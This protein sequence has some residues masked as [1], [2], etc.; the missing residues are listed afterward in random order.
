MLRRTAAWL[1]P[2]VTLLLSAEGCGGADIAGEPDAGPAQDS[3]TPA[4]D[5]ATSKP[6]TVT[7]SP[8]AEPLPGESACKVV[9]TTDIAVASAKHQLTCTAIAY[10]TNPPSG[11]DHWGPWA[12]YGKYTTR[13]PREMYVHNLEHGGVV[14][15]Y[16]CK[17]ACPEVVAA[18][19]AVFDDAADTFCATQS[20]PIARLVLTPDP[21]SPTPIA[22][23]AWG[24]TYTATCLDPPS[25]TDFVNRVIGHGTEKICGGGA[26]PVSVFATCS[27][28]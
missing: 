8:D 4:E 9:E 18:L 17:D 12:L 5:A 13:V 19:E 6:T 20:P 24:A 1:L 15:T 14:L 7:L 11:G 2:L 26:D 21:D 23:A 28:G 10:E 27:S 22:A 3:G 25:L 16:R